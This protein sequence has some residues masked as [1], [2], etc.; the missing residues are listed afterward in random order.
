MKHAVIFSHPNAQSFTASVAT[1]YRETAEG[2]GHSVVVRDLY[3]MKFDPCL[4]AE[5]LPRR[6]FQPA[7]DVAEERAVLKDADVFAFVYP[8]WL[9]A[10]PAMIKGYL[11]RVFG[12]GFAYGAGGRSAVPLLQ[13]RKLIS[14]S[15]SGAPLEWVQQT[16]AFAAVHTLYDRYIA[17]LCGMVSLEHVHF[18]NLAPEATSDFIEGRLADV[19]KAVR[20]HFAAA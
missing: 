11:E 5:E 2:L 16:G 3:R 6:D 17:D 8:L 1:A 4:K 12:Y 14:F 18:G 15:S 7:Q 13:G 19:R 9:N 20:R 10:P